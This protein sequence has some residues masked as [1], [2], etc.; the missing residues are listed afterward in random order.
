M[1]AS[2]SHAAA[3]TWQLRVPWDSIDAAGPDACWVVD[4]ACPSLV[5][6]TAWF[7]CSVIHNG[8]SAVVVG[9]ELS[10]CSAVQL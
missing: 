10:T 7:V 3:R 4:L 8:M 1:L 5:A 6:N 9:H 2:C